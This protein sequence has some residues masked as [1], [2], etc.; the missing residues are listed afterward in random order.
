MSGAYTSVAVTPADG[1]DLPN[2]PCD[3]IYVGVTG[4]VVY[5]GPATGSTSLTLKAA[6]VGYH[7]INMKRILSTGTTATNIL[8]L[9]DVK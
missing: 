5:Y 9:Y 4:D 7:P 3:W 1:T 2:G 6:A 8:A